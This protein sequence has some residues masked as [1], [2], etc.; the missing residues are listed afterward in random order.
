MLLQTPVGKRGHV[1][2]YLVSGSVRKVDGKW[3]F[4]DGIDKSAVAYGTISV[5]INE[6]GKPG[7]CL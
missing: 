7:F 6:T 5:A 4:S 1:L 2:Q 3:V